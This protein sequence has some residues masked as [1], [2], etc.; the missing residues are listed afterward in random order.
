MK[1][2]PQFIFS[3]QSQ[4]GMRDT[5]ET[6]QVK[7]SAD[8]T[9]KYVTLAYWLELKSLEKQQ[10]Q[11]GH[12]SPVFSLKAEEETPLWAV[13]PYTGG[14]FSLITRNRSQGWENSAH[15]C[16]DNFS[17]FTF[18]V[19]FTFPQFALSSNYCI[20]TSVFPL[21]RVFISLLRPWCSCKKKTLV[22]FS[23]INLSYVNFILKPTQKLQK[24]IGKKFSSPTQVR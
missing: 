14:K 16:H 6:I 24:S 12:L 11:E 17:S 19:F 7:G 3:S 4:V 13:P 18:P 21:L 15:D 2:L 8:A 23:L 1:I 5:V 22:F 20:N 9:P 10:A